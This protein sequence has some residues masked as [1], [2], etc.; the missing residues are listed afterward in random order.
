MHI[1]EAIR[2]CLQSIGCDR[3]VNYTTEKLG[4]VLK[5]EYPVSHTNLAGIPRWD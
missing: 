4:V 2:L 3:V 5:N 1:A